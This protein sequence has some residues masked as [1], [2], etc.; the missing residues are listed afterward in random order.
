MSSSTMAI[1]VKK[2]WRIYLILGVSLVSLGLLAVDFG[3]FAAHTI[4]CWSGKYGSQYYLAGC[5]N[6]R[7]IEYDM[8]AIYYGLEDGISETIKNAQVIVLGSSK[9][10]AA[11]SS[12]ATEAYF[13]KQN[14]RFYVLGFG[15]NNLGGFALP[16]LKHKQANPKLLIVGADPFFITQL[17]PLTDDILTGDWSAYW[18]HVFI[19]GVQRLQRAVCPTFPSLCSPPFRTIY[20]SAKTGQW[21]WLGSYFPEQSIP[22]NDMLHPEFTDGEFQAAVE[23][24]ERFL[25][26]AGIDRNC[27]V[28]TGV[29]NNERDSPAIASRLAQR[30][31]TK[32]ILPEVEPLA[33]LDDTHLN[34]DSAERWSAAFLTELTSVLDSCLPR[35]R[36]R[37]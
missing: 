1:K 10:Q 8:G 15:Y 27:I 37:D 35:N 9:A 2:R 24:G 31:G 16:L 11:F 32:L 30:L 3:Y 33:L 21:K 14:A 17:P 20:R 7:L 5:H 4:Q 22:L 23:F 6:R 12:S 25:R 28:F 18:N 13:A 36:S 29:P 26:E 34:F 19:A